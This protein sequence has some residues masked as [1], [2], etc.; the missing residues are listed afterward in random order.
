MK[1]FL[2]AMFGILVAM[3][4][5]TGFG[6]EYWRENKVT[7]RKTNWTDSVVVKNLPEDINS[8][9]S[10]FKSIFCEKNYQNIITRLDSAKQLNEGRVGF[11]GAYTWEFACYEQLVAI[12]TDNQ[13]IYLLKHKN[14]IVRAYSFKALAARNNSLAERNLYILKNDTAKIRTLSGCL[15]MIEPVN[16]FASSCIKN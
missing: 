6:F 12:T 5:V 3:V 16:S 13:L 7:A 8:D 2:L 14:P 1:L 10:L 9:D 11:A 4:L 15:G